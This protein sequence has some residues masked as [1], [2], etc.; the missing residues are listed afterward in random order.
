M[1]I[2]VCYDKI[3]YDEDIALFEAT[4]H[5]PVK[6][7]DHSCKT[8]HSYENGQQE[9]EIGKYLYYSLQIRLFGVLEKFRMKYMLTDAYV[10]YIVEY[11]INLYYVLNATIRHISH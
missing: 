8:C 9:S 2:M 4:G 7:E 11:I 10:K 1:V 3:F 5:I 6:R